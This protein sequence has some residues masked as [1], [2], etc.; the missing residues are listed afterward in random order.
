MKWA[1]P[2]EELQVG[3]TFVTAGR[4]VTAA[5]V[6]AFAALTGDHHPVH[7]DAEWAATSTFGEQ[8]AHGLLVLSCAVGLVPLDPQRVVAL[9]RV[10]DAVFKRPVT[11]G[12]EIHV[13]GE[14]DRLRPVSDHA[15][16]VGCRWAIVNSRGELCTR[17][18][19][20]LLWRTAAPVTV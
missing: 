4:T 17:A 18:S 3:S 19:V 6:G 8:I 7:T 16:L 9:R 10:T 11:F 5:D 20:E 2:F 12:E 14:I 1:A 13:E 15:G